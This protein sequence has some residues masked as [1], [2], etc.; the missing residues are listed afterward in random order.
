MFGGVAI[1]VMSLFM[2]H[3]LVLHERIEKIEQQNFDFT[4]KWEIKYWT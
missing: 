4:K 1:Y 2:L 3:F